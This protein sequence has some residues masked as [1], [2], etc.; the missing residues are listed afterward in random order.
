M[1]V[2]YRFLQI[3]QPVSDICDS[4]AGRETSS[5]GYGCPL[6]AGVF[7]KSAETEDPVIGIS[8]TRT[9]SPS[10]FFVALKHHCFVHL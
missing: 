10:L 1:I 6:L 5:F 4:R 3:L 2:S 8:R 9:E 7:I